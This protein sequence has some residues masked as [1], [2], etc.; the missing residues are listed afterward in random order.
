MSF[1]V[2]LSVYSKENPF[3]LNEALS[4]IWDQQTLKPGQIVLVK[5]GPLTEELDNCINIW[6]Q[7]LGEILSIVELPENVGLG[8]A[9]NEGL[10]Q[11][12]YELIAR[13]D[14]DD[15]SLPKRFEKQVSF[16]EENPG[17]AASSAILE[18]WDV[19]FEKYIG[20]RALPLKP[21]ELEKFAKYRSPLSHPVAI[22]RKSIILELDGYPAFRRAQDYPLWSVLL[23]NGYKLANLPDILY[24]QRA[25]NTLL[26][27]RGLSHFKNELKIFN[28]QHKIGFLNIYEFLRNILIRLI[29]RMVPNFIKRFFYKYRNIR[30][31][32]F[33]IVF[34]DIILLLLA[35][36]LSVW[37]RYLE[38]PSEH[39]L[40][41][42]YPQFIPIIAAWI[43]C[44]YFAGFYSLEIPRMGY[45]LLSNLSIIAI[46]CT[47]LSFGY[48]Y[49]N[50][51]FKRGPRTILIIYSFNVT[52]LILLWRLFLNKIAVK[53]TARINVGF[54]GINDAVIN[55]LQDRKYNT[56]MK[57]NMVF[58]YD[59]NHTQADE[60][61]NVPII[62]EAPVFIDAIKKNNV[63]II[64]FA[65]EKKLSK[66]MQNVL[67]EL[68]KYN[69]KM[70]NIPEFY[71]VF[72][73]RLPLDAINEM[74]LLGNY[75]MQLKRIYSIFKRMIDFLMAFAL[76]ILSLPLW[77]F[78]I[79]LIKLECPGN[80]LLKQE[81]SGYLGKPFM[82]LKFRTFKKIDD[83]NSTT[84]TGSFLRKAHLDKLPQ[85]L[86]IIKSDMSFIGPRPERTELIL[87]F[88]KEVPF[89]R[90]RLLVKPGISGWDQVSGE[91]HSPSAEDTYKKLQYDLYYIKNMSFFL[92]VS[93][94]LK[95]LVTLFIPKSA[96]S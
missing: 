7:I 47:V 83:G 93:I 43:A 77:P 40:I 92:D 17:I 84:R 10:K 94:F 16:M 90:Q 31:Y 64:A 96:G 82:R 1:S 29:I 25:G 13:M 79:L 18:E 69:V 24:K 60:Y 30:K 22:F 74:K 65:E 4:S 8:V 12:K 5:D 46:I 88:E 28:F 80:V 21:Q 58:L 39:R 35:V 15:I 41:R 20:I 86:N 56:R 27:R 91:Y 57:Y 11:C 73:R 70:I 6:K 42:L 52:I 76:C 75:N 48:F 78:I 51:E 38:F 34:V 3:F 89:Y 9:L 45:R 53:Y 23:V 81:C 87:E 50:I 14:T 68:I 67:F 66:S 49:L 33:L 62:K 19:K 37:L 36:S 59:E 85:F 26:K 95:T 2:L 72:T 61:S 32:Q 71:E 63:Q 44:F 54:V 55:L